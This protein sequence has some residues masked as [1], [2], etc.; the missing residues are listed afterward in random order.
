MLNKYYQFLDTIN[1]KYDI[2]EN[3]DKIVK[4]KEKSPD[5]ERN[6]IFTIKEEHPTIKNDS[7]LS[8]IKVEIDLINKD[9]NR[10]IKN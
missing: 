9:L 3:E 6:V 4:K 7:N 5:L 2:N 1:K 8:L 10:L